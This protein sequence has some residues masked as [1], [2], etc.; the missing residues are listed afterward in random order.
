MNALRRWWKLALAMAGLL[1]AAQI[2][3]SLLV[4]THGVHNFLVAQL[5]RAFG[6]P[7]EVRH[8]GARLLPSPTL[9]ASGITVGEDPAFGNE[10]FLRAESFS[11]G[12]R[13]TGL[14]RGRFEFG[15][16]AFARPSL[17]LVRNPEGRW[18]LER[19][20][21]PAKSSAA[22]RA[23]FYGPTQATPSNHLQKIEFD[24]GRVNFKLEYDK[25]TFAFTDVSG[26]VEQIAPGRWELQLAATPWRSGVALQSTGRV[27]VLGDL[28][29][30]STRLQPA[31]V[32][33]HWDEASLADIFRLWSGQDYGVRGVFA[34]EATLQSGI[35]APD[36]TPAPPAPLPGGWTF[37]VH[38]RATRIHRWDFAERSDN[39]RLNAS[40]KGNFFSDTRAVEPAHFSMEAPQ[41]NLRGYFSIGGFAQ[42]DIL[43]RVDSMG[44]QAAD[45]LAWCR[46]FQ[47]DID[48]GISVQQFF[49]GSA[50]LRGWPLQLESAGFSSAGGTL[51]IPGIDGG[52]QIGALRGGRERSKLAVEPVRISWNSAASVA[53]AAEPST[54]AVRRKAADARSAVS[55]GLTH[56]FTRGEG[57]LTLDGHAAKAEQI[58]HIARAFGRPLNRG[59]ELTGDA[60]AALQWNWSAG[61]RGRW[62]GKLGFSLAQLQVAGLNQPLLL[63]EAELDY[64]DGRRIAEI[65]KAQ[66]FGAN[67]SGEIAQWQSA[68]A[69]TDAEAK[70]QFQL[71]ADKIDAA[72]L[73]RWVGP[74]ARPGWLQRVMNSLLG[75]ANANSAAAIP[76]SELLRR[77]NAEGE[78]RIDDLT[79][80]KLTLRDVHATGSLHDLQ[81][82]IREADAQWAGGSVRG[83]GRAQF[84]PKP[85]YEVSVEFDRVNLAQ[86]PDA[87]AARLAGLASGKLH[88][89]A[90]GVGREVLLKSLEG[91]AQVRVKNVELRGWDVPAS[92]ADG[93]AH[94]G[95]SRWTAGAGLLRFRDRGVLLDD[96]HLENGKE[97]TLINGRVTFGQDADLSMET[98]AGGKHASNFVGAGRVLK[99]SGP[100]DLPRVSVENAVARQPAD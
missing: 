71:H 24:E 8:F 89:A 27:R 94:A 5:S 15:T 1:I 34:L 65:A 63:D 81:T 78:L 46:A 54:V 3:V 2:G 22:D 32:Q 29:G 35:A 72:D 77:V 28:A 85:G 57:A 97:L 13:W 9:A 70:W 42:P 98:S 75:G 44:V 45:L 91:T 87:F 40:V 66:G 50:M 96:F 56:D 26:S 33:V 21:P 99:I 41:S 48:E 17:I 14:L 19:W 67:W 47:S 88:L 36:A 6:R 11:A 59:W 79:V 39:P 58:L 92:M 64:K 84:A 4:R 23:V 82:E 90:A 86:L 55:V 83:S 7:V 51:K 93:T 10:Y 53:G 20:L 69:A 52:V 30:T 68:T 76:A 61:K 38:A 100:L 80:E 25:Q 18:N 37:S 95:V 49:T 62:N 73:D 60:N 74:R 16:L 31:Q 12:L 43:L